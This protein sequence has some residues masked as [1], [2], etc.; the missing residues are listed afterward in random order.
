M[1]IIEKVEELGRL[2]ADS[3]CIALIGHVN[4][5]GDSIGSLIGLS[6]YLQ[7]LGKQIMPIVPNNYPFFLKFIDS[8]EKIIIYNKAFEYVN[9]FIQKANLIICMD[10]NGLRRIDEL[11]KVI[12]KS[13]AVKVLIDHH[14]QPEP[15]FNLVY[16]YPNL[17]STCEV[18]YWILKRLCGNKVMSMESANALYTGMMTDTNNFSNS[19]Q[20]S[21]FKMAGELLDVGVNKEWVQM[22]VFGGF[23]EL[24]MRLMGYMLCENMRLIL[25][26]KAGVMLLTNEIKKRF[27]LEDGDTEGF[28]NLP[29]SIKGIEVSALFTQEKDYVKV[30]LRSKNSFSVNRFARLYFNGGGHER[31]AGG[32]L[33]LSIEKVEE[34]FIKSIEEFTEKEK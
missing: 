2:I 9:E 29:L 22:N 7:G 30:S 12:E 28:V 21:T 17:S 6:S 4:P 31:A 10:F 34:Y 25:P 14:P 11:G 8:E 32:K 3:E 26:Y 19:V 5:D 20:A 24:R 27:S 15:V 33:Y 13:L 23:N 18:T 16:S 1:E